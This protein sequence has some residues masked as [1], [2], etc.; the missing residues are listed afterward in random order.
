M[1]TYVPEEH[2][3]RAEKDQGSFDLILFKNLRFDFRIK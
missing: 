3:I 2:I 1:E